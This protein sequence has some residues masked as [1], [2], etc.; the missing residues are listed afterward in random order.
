MTSPTVEAHKALGEYRL[1]VDAAC[2]SAERFHADAVAVGRVAA[3][4]QPLLG[5]AGVEMAAIGWEGQPPVAEWAAQVPV[6]TSIV[7]SALQGA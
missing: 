6:V 1:A 4:L 2:R 7:K 5:E 3:T